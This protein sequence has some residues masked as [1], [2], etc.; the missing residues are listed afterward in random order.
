M[1]VAF[2]VGAQIEDELRIALAVPDDALFHVGTTATPG[3]E[4]AR[5]QAVRLGLVVEMCFSPRGDRRERNRHM[6]EHADAVVVVCDPGR[7][8]DMDDLVAQ[9]T[10]R[11]VPLTLA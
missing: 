10:E 7:D 8:P 6:V 9:A 1:R 11:G 5:R 4:L 2:A 3:D